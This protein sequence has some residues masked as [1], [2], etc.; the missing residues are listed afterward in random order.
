MP[1]VV[2]LILNIA[3]LNDHRKYCL[4]VR[5]VDEFNIQSSKYLG[6][7]SRHLFRYSIYIIMCQ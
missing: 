3:R 4:C 2:S 5:L 1:G 7:E 6:P